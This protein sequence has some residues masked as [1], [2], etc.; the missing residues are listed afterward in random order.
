MDRF[1]FFLKRSFRYENDDEK[2]K[3]ETIVLK[4]IVYKKLVVS[5]TIVNEERRRE[6]TDLKGIGTYY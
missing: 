4:T 1:N 3:N 2:T 6:K 5:L